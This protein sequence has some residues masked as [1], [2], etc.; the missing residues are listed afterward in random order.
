MRAHQRR[1][2][3]PGQRAAPRRHVQVE[4]QRDDAGR[5]ARPASHAEVVVDVKEDDVGMDGSQHVD[6]RRA[7]Q[8]RGDV[9]MPGDGCP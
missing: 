3:P 8:L 5:R 9:G 7:S 1:D 4:L 2:R 6:E